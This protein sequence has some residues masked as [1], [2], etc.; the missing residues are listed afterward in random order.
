ML[1]LLMCVRRMP[2]YLNSPRSS[3][4]GTRGRSQ[5]RALC[6]L[7]IAALLGTV[8]TLHAATA[9]ASWNPNP[10]ADIAG[11]KLSYGTQS[12]VYTTVIDVGN[13]TGWSV[14]LTAGQR[15]F[16]AVQAYNTSSL[17]SAYSAEAID[18]VPAVSPPSIASLTP[19][20]GPSG[21]VVTITGTNFGATQGSS[22]VAFN[23]TTATATS[24]SVTSIVVPVTPGAT[25]GN[26]VVNVGGLASNGM[27]FTVTVPPNITSLSPTSGPVGTA[28]TITGS[29]FGATQGASTIKFNGTTATPT[30]WSPASIA[31][32]V[33]AGAT[34]GN[35]AVTVG[36][37]VSNGVSF[38]VTVPPN[39]TSLSPT[40]GPVGAAVTIT[41]STFGATQGTSTIKFNGSTATPT[42]WSAAS[43]VVPAP[44]AATTGNVVITVG[45]LVSNGVSFTV[46]VPPNITSLSPT[47]G[48]VGTA[49]TITGSSF[50]ASQGTSTIK[51]NGTTATPTSWSATS[52]VVHVLS[53]ATSGNLVVTVGGLAS[54]GVSFTVTVPP[55]APTGLKIGG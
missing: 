12:G 7:V 21:T 40:S 17:L 29:T 32:P 14:T 31:V 26:V 51:F 49:V 37:L 13:V 39:I 41:G 30:S 16:F 52:I 54:N 35:V 20:S 45:G 43:I 46:L 6:V 23:G 47:I 24:W 9:T 33:P 4:P 25:T 42:S 15:Y 28:V 34:T 8:S 3:S 10:E 1:Q 27:S 38:T 48:P 50:G 19:T 18:D 5:A 44:A 53:G 22:T 55:G 11:Y 2:T 36:G